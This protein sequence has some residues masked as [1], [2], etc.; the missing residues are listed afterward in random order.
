MDPKLSAAID[1]LK[2]EAIELIGLAKQDKTTRDG[3]GVILSF[4]GR[5]ESDN[6]KKLLLV[7]LARN[8]YPIETTLELGNILGLK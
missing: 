4:M 7:A 8:G 1:S 3:Y 2:E 5:L 6:M